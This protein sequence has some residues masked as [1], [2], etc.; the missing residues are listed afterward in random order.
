M[1]LQD[2]G[3]AVKI[4]DRIV[5]AVNIQVTNVPGYLEH[6]VGPPAWYGVYFEIL[7]EDGDL[8]VV[9]NGPCESEAND[10]Y[11]WVTVYYNW[12]KVGD[13]DQGALLAYDWKD[14]VGR[15]YDEK[16]GSFETRGI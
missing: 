13:E 16:V 1:E 6:E 10:P 3:N 7:F 5:P 4:L 14:F 12:A 8:W 2:M 15:L 11:V 9:E